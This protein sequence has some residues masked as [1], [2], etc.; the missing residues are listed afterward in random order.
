MS[1]ERARRVAHAAGVAAAAWMGWRCLQLWRLVAAEWGGLR[2]RADDA[3]LAARL[4]QLKP[5]PFKVP[6]SIA[7]LALFLGICLGVIALLSARAITARRS[8]GTSP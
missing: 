6:W 3:V 2:E 4:S 7:Y 8:G 5:A 1:V